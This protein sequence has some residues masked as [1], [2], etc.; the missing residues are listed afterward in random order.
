MQ[1]MRPRIGFLVVCAALIATGVSSMAVAAQSQTSQS[2]CYSTCASSTRLTQST[3]LVRYGGEELQFFHVTVS[4]AVLGLTQA[5]TGTV[6]IRSGSTTLCTIVLPARRGSCSPSPRALPPGFYGVRGYYS[7]DATFSPSVS[8]V[9][10][11]QI[12]SLGLK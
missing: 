7:G 10:T 11:F 9:Q 3:T 12:R 6:T 2:V 5:P 4:P 8:N 1:I